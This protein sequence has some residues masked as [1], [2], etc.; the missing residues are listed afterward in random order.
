MRHL[1]VLLLLVGTCSLQA[2]RAQSIPRNDLPRFTVEGNAPGTR[3][4]I[5]LITFGVSMSDCIQSVEIEN[6]ENKRKYMLYPTLDNYFVRD[7]DMEEIYAKIPVGKFRKLVDKKDGLQ[8]QITIISKSGR[9][10]YYGKAEI[11]IETGDDDDKEDAK[12][13]RTASR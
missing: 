8:A 9:R 5:V 12:D 10:V 4:G 3:S 6:L 1:F 13:K 11:K 7:S 2:V